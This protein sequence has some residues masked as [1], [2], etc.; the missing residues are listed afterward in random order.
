MP[1]I[2]LAEL[3]VILVVVLI[4]FGPKSLPKLGASIGRTVKNFRDGMEG[5]DS[6]ADD[7]VDADATVNGSG[8]VDS[9][10]SADDKVE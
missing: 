1:R 9:T 4:I 6:A 3:I 7:K 2:G 8:K 10:G 5:K